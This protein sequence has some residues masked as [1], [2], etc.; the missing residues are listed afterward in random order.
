MKW[1]ALLP[2]AVVFAGLLVPDA[3][4]SCSCEPPGTPLE[5]L[6]SHDAVFTGR[7]VEIAE[8]PEEDVWILFKLS[9][10]WKGGLGEDIAI[11]TRQTDAE[12]RGFRQLLSHADSPEDFWYSSPSLSRREEFLLTMDLMDS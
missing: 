8:T 9:A 5:A 7:V 11:R 6:A 4:L 12:S 2:L 1:I 10:V 3:S